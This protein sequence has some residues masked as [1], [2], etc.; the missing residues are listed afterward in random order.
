MLT[1]KIAVVKVGANS[2]VELKE[3]LIELKMLFVQ[4][5]A[6]VKEGIVPGGGVALLNASTY[7]KSKGLGEEVL[8]KA[9]KAP[10]FT[11]LEKCRYHSIAAAR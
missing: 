1:A 10:Y 9:I 11:I 3:K 8:L 4:T 7:I 5:K 2:E 6:A